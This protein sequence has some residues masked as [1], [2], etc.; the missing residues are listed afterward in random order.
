MVDAVKDLIERLE[1]KAPRDTNGRF[2]PRL[3]NDPNC[4]G[5]LVLDSYVSLGVVY[6]V[7][8]CDGLTHQ[9]DDGPLEACGR[10]YAAARAALKARQ[11]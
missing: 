4:D 10:S 7:W 6:P 9:T 1:A 3:C 8:R 2:L 5:S 11:P